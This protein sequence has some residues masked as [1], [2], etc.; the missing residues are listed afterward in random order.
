MRELLTLAASEPV[1]DKPW[2]LTLEERVGITT[3]EALENTASELEATGLKKLGKIVREHA[4]GRPREID[5]P[6]YEP[7]TIDHRAW[8]ASM[9]CKGKL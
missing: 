6:P 9:K 1:P 2:L 4:A 5:L 3:R 7:E 8:L